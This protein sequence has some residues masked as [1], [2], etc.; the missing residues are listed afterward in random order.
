M[1]SLERAM[2]SLA[3]AC[4]GAV[5]IAA[6][7]ARH[8][9][10]ELP[11]DARDRVPFYGCMGKEISLGLGLALAQPRRQVIVLSGDGS[12]M[13]NL[14]ALITV[15]EHAPPNLLH[16]VVDN[17]VY[18]TTGGQLLP[19]SKQLELAGFARAAGYPVVWVIADEE[20]ADAQL[21]AL[22]GGQLAF[23]QL[24]VAPL[25]RR[26]PAPRRMQQSLHELRASSLERPA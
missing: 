22:V 9:V 16:I 13:M 18:A 26:P 12:L 25:L 23:V 19:G 17:G 10:D 1:L 20:R 15:A 8:Y 6:H 3:S 5:V 14:G 11:G 4:E 2:Q 21:P 7:S 24:V